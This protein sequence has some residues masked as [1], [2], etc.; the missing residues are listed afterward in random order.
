MHNVAGEKVYTAQFVVTS[1]RR[2]HSN[3]RQQKF[4]CLFPPPRVWCLDA[5]LPVTVGLYQG[6]PRTD[7]LHEVVLALPQR[8]QQRLP[9]LLPHAV[10]VELQR[11]RRESLPSH[12]ERLVEAVETVQGPEREIDLTLHSVIYYYAR[13]TFPTGNEILICFKFSR[14]VNQ[15]FIELGKPSK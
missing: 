4:H 7:H 15:N 12:G 11:T 9:P 5:A 14:K 1:L 8:P 6:G 13:R 10:E 2:I 3:N